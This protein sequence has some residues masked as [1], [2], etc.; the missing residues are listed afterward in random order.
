[1]T[2]LPAPPRPSQHDPVAIA[3]AE[4]I[5]S[6]DLTSRYFVGTEDRNARIFAKESAVAAGVETAA[7]VFARVDP[8]LALKVVRP[9]GTALQPGDTV[10]E[11]S[12]A[13][14]S[15][16]DRLVTIPSMGDGTSLPLSHAASVVMAEAMRQRLALTKTTA[17]APP[18]PDHSPQDP[19]ST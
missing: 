17:P 9:S 7:E 6:G 3:L 8:Q 10:L 14:R 5:G 19:S 1:M 18:L 12:G 16:C 11:I 4:D 13:V 2:V 15:I